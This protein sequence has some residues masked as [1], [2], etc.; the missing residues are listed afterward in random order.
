MSFSSVRKWNI[1]S[2][3]CLME[4]HGHEA[5]VYRSVGVANSGCGLIVGVVY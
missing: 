5:Y 1:H 4:F 3:Q 2:A